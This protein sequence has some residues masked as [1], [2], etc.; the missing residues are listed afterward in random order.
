MKSLL[1]LCVLVLSGCASSPY[2]TT[3]DRSAF[4]LKDPQR[5]GYK[6]YDPCIR[7]GESWTFLNIDQTQHLK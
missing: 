3:S 6:D 5:H 4:L 7:C 2:P 1:A